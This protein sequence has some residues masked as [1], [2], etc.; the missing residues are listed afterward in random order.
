MLLILTMLV[1][2][3]FLGMGARG[4]IDESRRLDPPAAPAP[5]ARRPPVGDGARDEFVYKTRS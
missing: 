3:F 1:A 2:L 5:T 4:E